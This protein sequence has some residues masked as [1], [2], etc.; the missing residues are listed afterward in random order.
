MS[1]PNS[2]GESHAQHAPHHAAAAPHA[3]T[4]GSADR[5]PARGRGRLADGPGSDRVAGEQ[6]HPQ[7]RH[8]RAERAG[9]PGLPVRR[10]GHRVAESVDA[11]GSAAE[12]SAGGRQ[13]IVHGRQHIHRNSGVVRVAS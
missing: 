4:V 9:R 12:R 7:L 8:G 6:S 10:L 13:P 1:P 2:G 3:G 5:M 11:G